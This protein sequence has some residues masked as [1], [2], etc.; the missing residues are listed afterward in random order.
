MGL[1]YDYPSKG[2]SCLDGPLKVKYDGKP[3]GEIRKVKDGFQFFA[4]GDKTG[5]PICNN[6]S[7]VQN[8]LVALQPSKEDRKGSDEKET[9]EDQ[10][11]SMIKK[12]KRE[13]KATNSK[14]EAA[15]VLLTAS[16]D[17]FEKQ[18]GTTE[19]VNMLEEN[20]TCGETEMDGHSVHADIGK[21]LEDV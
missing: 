21:Y 2:K 5:G 1:D 3:F 6:V 11:V 13:L 8:S 7:E 12:I 10:S 18:V 15:L 4:K 9:T 17:L 14:L 19:P 16:F 20:V